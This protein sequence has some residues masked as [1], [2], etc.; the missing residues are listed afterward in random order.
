M[1]NKRLSATITIGGAITGALK[2]ALGQTR[3]GLDQIGASVRK[4][5]R[6]QKMLGSSI[7]TLG[8]SGMNVE[9]LRNRYAELTEQISKARQQQQRLASAHKA[10]NAGSAMMGGAGVALGA[11]GLAMVPVMSTAKNASEFEYQLRMIG[12]TANMSRGEVKALG[13]QIM[14][15]GQQTGQSAD[16]MTRAMGF[17]VA[18]GMDVGTAR[19][20]LAQIGKAATA[21]GGDIEDLAKAAFTLNDTMGIKAGAEMVA[22]L[23][24]LAQAGKEGNVELKDMAKQL[25]VLGSGFQAL[26]MGG[27]EAAATMAAALE[28]A[29]KGAADAD[30][31][32]NNMKNFIAKVM[33]PETLKK[34]QK[35]FGIDLYKIIQDAQ[36]KGGN[37]FEAAMQAI[38]KATKGDQKAIGE[39]FGDMQV[40]NFIRPMMQNWD[41]YV[42]IKGKALGAS[43][44]VDQDFELV[45]ETAKQRMNEMSAAVDR[46]S[47]AFGTV[48]LPALGSVLA[49]LTPLVAGVADFVSNNQ[50]LV[51]N[52]ATV[53]GTLGSMFVATKT[54]AFGIGAV[55]W[56]FGALKLAM[57][58]N[59]IGLALV[60]LTT[61]AVLVYKNWEPIKGFF[62][63][64]WNSVVSGA[65]AAFE[66][67]MGKLAVVGEYWGKFKA[68]LGFGAGAPMA[69]GPIMPALPPV[70]S[71]ATARNGMS[72]T[73][74][75]ANTFNITQL[76][77]QDSKALAD[78]IMRRLAEKQAVQQR[79]RFYDMALGY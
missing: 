57:A 76:P 77:G 66:W 17:L 39:L 45:R 68:A 2:S 36:T 70:P 54:A 25:P 6:E 40:Q 61:A 72:A 52:I 3:S 29:R 34:A 71:L 23:D 30:E 1:T 9:G 73:T 33:S 20:M 53:V 13:E 27:R 37:P 56:A 22:A 75:Q 24:T 12:N 60:A 44:I 31:A 11:A 63:D 5:E 8:R 26:K 38:T 19:D 78:E 7:Q 18:A 50:V 4:L 15:A 62:V 21:T 28:V 10:M 49:V 32:A 43:G 64:L 67:V 79:G 51:G 35:S 41:E 65:K 59:P 47:K 58:T 74:N 48:L 14:A 42:R 16:N 55:T 46:A 69:A